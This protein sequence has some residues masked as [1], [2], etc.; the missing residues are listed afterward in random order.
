MKVVVDL[1]DRRAVW[2]M[3]E[4][5][6]ERLEGALDVGA[7]LV[8]IDAPADGTGDGSARVDPHVLREISD[9]DVYMGFGIPAEVLTTGG[10]L[11][12]VHTGAAGVGGSL[13]PAMLASDVLFT[14]SAGVHANP[15][16]ETV[17]S[18][19]LYF[20]RG[21]G[22]ALRA[23]SEGRWDSASFYDAEVQLG[24][25]GRST[26]GIVGFG[27]IGRAVASRAAALGARVIGLKRR[28]EGTGEV[29]LE[30][31]GERGPR[32]VIG[33]A[34]VLSGKQGLE[35]LLEASDYVVVTAPSTSDSVGMIGREELAR[36]KEGAVLVNVS[37]GALVDESA[38]IEALE[39]GRLRGAALDVFTKEPLAEGHPLWAMPNVLVTPHVSAVSRA[40]WERET[41][42]ITDN[43]RRFQRGEPL[44]NV[45][46][47]KAGY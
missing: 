6:P 12:W 31:P 39:S 43:L 30:S 46:D 15:M 42:L 20:A 28:T 10:R 25:L 7:E 11:R 21:L 37:R 36:I 17:L 40:F 47:K 24:E 5:V 13:T 32:V 9:A 38:L 34:S 16:A 35:E 33:S 14:N 18:M 19:I 23:Q 44:L 29:P 2:A 1:Q 4:W 45:V 8:M 26:V 41:Q 27:G 3:P 22:A